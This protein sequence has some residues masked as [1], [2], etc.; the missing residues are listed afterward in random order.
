MEA[1]EEVEEE[2]VEE[3]AAQAAAMPEV[4]TAR[5]QTS[6]AAVQ[7]EEVAAATAV[8]AMRAR[9]AIYHASSFVAWRRRMCAKRL[10]LR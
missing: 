4:A 5:V 8:A 9:L 2:V 6:V 10:R 7:E 1:M 3:A